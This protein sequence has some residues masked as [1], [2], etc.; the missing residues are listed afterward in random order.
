MIG[1]INGLF[2]THDAAIAVEKLGRLWRKNGADWRPIEMSVA[3]HLLARQGSSE[4]GASLVRELAESVGPRSHELD[5]QSLATTVWAVAQLGVGARPVW[6]PLV[7][8]ALRIGPVDPRAFSVT[9]WAVAVGVVAGH[10]DRGDLVTLLG[11]TP[12]GPGW[13]DVLQPTSLL[14]LHHAG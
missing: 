13:A 6:A 9:A 1:R 8:T 5:R 14:Q 3:L 7:G 12:R 4:L 2:R 10:V 11:Q